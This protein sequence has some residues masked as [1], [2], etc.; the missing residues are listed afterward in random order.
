L[1]NYRHLQTSNVLLDVLRSVRFQGEG[2]SSISF[3]I[4]GNGMTSY[5]VRNLALVGGSLQ[6]RRV[7][8]W[9]PES[10]NFTFFNTV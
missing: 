8:E 1:Q 3:D 9:N 4:N 5:D 10:Q 6:L 7:G 2:S